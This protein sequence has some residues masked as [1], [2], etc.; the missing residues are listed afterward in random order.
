M[1]MEEG[2]LDSEDGSQDLRSERR[3]VVMERL[4]ARGGDD[5]RWRTYSCWSGI[6]HRLD[7]AA[8]PSPLAERGERSLRDVSDLAE[9]AANLCRR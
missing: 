3:N 1:W 5:S 9:A 6:W 4:K 8:E 7:E 2:E